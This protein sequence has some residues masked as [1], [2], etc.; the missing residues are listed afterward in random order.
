MDQVEEIKRKIDIVEIIGE[1]V[2]LKRAGK[3]FRGL[4]PFHSEKTPSFMVTPE[5]Q[6]F[7]CFGCNL[8]GDVY[9]FL[10]EFEKIEFPEALKILADRAGIK[11]KPLRGFPE[12][13]NKEEIYRINHLLSELYHHILVS[14]KLGLSALGYLLKERGIKKES[15]ETFKLGFAPDSPDFVFRFL[16][17]KRGYQP[18]LLE[19][20]GIAVRRESGYFDRFRGRIIFPLRDQFG[21]VLGFSG[22]VLKETG[23]VAKYI[24]TPDT[25]VYKKGRVLYGLEAGKPDIKKQEFAVL[26]EGVFDAISSWQAG[27]KNVVA[28]TGTAL[29]A[30]QARLIMRF[31]P[32]IVL[33]LDTDSAGLEAARRAVEVAE[34]EGLEVRI[35]RIAGFKDPDEMA[36]KDSEAWKKAVLGAVGVYDFLIDLVFSRFDAGTPEGKGRISRFIAPILARINDEILKAHFV[37]QVAGRL[38]VPES[39]VLAQVAKQKPVAPKTETDLQVPQRTKNRRDLLEEYLLALLFQTS[40]GLV[41]EVEPLVKTPGAKRIVEEFGKLQKNS[42]EFDPSHFASSLSPELIEL[43]AS[44]V[45]RDIERV[46]AQGQVEDEIKRTR[47]ELEILNIRETMGGIA[48][49]IRELEK[50]GEAGEVGLLEAELKEAG[51]KLARFEAGP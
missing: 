35:A 44:F 18:Q 30:D 4:C 19:K 39:A 28:I 31:C 38:D 11:L 41:G 43:F 20:A 34:K 16:T 50:A 33:A 42:P 47:R 14:H 51:N 15:I 10:M 49:R 6:I 27:V 45:L 9:R 7:K 17:V 3:N 21:N 8:G 37:K 22:R 1:H 26:V 36:R 40:P 32:T 46:L 13:Q 12:Y 48:Q 24:N 25:P 5:L 23:D 2:P 29:T